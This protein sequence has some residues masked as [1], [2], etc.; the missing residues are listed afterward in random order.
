MKTL[1]FEGAGW[2]KAQVGKTDVPN[3]RI[4]TAFTNDEGRKVYLEILA[5]EVRKDR[6]Q[7]IGI[8][9]G[10]AAGYIDSAH[11]ITDD[12]KIDD[13]NASRI[14]LENRYILYNY[15][16][17]KEYINKNFK[18]S[19]EKIQVLNELTGFRVF[20][21]GGKYGTFAFYNY[22]DEFQFDEEKTRKRLEKAEELKQYFETFM[23]YD[24]SSYWVADNGDLMVRINTYDAVFQKMKFPERQFQVAI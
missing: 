9:A 20:N 18:C 5:H 14:N 21:D 1:Y 8:E 11:W 4:R 16:T 15:E 2:S 22:G 24:N 19:F 10:M 6:S 7:D 3:C 13:C 23:K 12:P 17:L